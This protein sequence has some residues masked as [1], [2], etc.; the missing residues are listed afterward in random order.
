LGIDVARE[1]KKLE[2][3]KGIPDEVETC[4]E[5]IACYNLCMCFV[6]KLQQGIRGLSVSD[7]HEI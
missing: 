1:R 7:G 5:F 2:Y 3:I 4:K 6:F